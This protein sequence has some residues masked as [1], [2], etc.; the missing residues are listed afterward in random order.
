[1]PNVIDYLKWRGDLT[2]SQFPF[3]EVDNLILSYLS[4][5]NLDG[6][7]PAPQMGSVTV[8]E[9]SELFFDFHTQEE[10]EADR[11]FIRLAPYMMGEMAKTARFQ[12]AKVK[13]YVNEVTQEEEMQFSA[14]ELILDD[15]SSYIAYRGTDDTIVGWKEDF[16]L[17]TGLVPAQEAA[18]AYLNQAAGESARMLRVGGHSKGGNLAVYA[19]AMCDE[20]VQERIKAVYCNDGPGFLESFFDEPG[21]KR[22]E[23][24]IRRYIPESSVIGMLF[25][26]TS[27]PVIIRSSQKGILQHDGLSWQVLG[28]GFERADEL[29]RKA[30]LF[31]ETLHHWID[32]LEPE[33]RAAVVGD[34]FAVLEATGA[35]TLTRLQEGGIGYAKVMLKQVEKLSPD[36]KS[37]VDELLK[38]LFSHWKEFVLDQGEIRAAECETQPCVHGR[39]DTDGEE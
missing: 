19:A 18:T 20:K 32:D 34:F 29:N 2:F 30:A 33:K 35:Q 6:I 31:N 15:G 22:I 28:P 10:L 14:V 25:L 4:Y 23:S 26:H 37:A 38:S 5:V 17:S 24:R 16:H 3:C 36:T 21:L 12:N 13:N 9:L 39:K 7:A 11:S 8:K 27:A 1:M